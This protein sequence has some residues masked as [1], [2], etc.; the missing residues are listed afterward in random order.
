MTGSVSGGEVV[1]SVFAVSGAAVTSEERSDSIMRQELSERRIERIT[2]AI[3]SDLLFILPSESSEP[4]ATDGSVFKGRKS[5]G[6]GILL[7]Y[8]PFCAD[9]FCGIEHCSHID[10]AV[11]HGA[12]LKALGVAKITLFVII[13]T[14]EVE[15]IQMNEGTEAV[16]SHHIIGCISVARG[17]PADVY[18]GKEIIVSRIPEDKIELVF[19]VCLLELPGVVMIEDLYAVLLKVCTCTVEALYHFIVSRLF[20]LVIAPKCGYGKI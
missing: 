12:E 19:A 13:S 4:V 8:H 2:A 18:L 1:S 5:E 9:C 16:V 11:S 3:I 10:S 7:N 20:V 17:S 6:R 14:L 15:I